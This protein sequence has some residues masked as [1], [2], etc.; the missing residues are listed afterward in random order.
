MLGERIGTGAVF[1]VTGISAAGKSTVA[2]LLARRFSRGV[3]VRGDVFRRMVV[4]GRQD[5][6][7]NGSDESRA[8][9]R[10]RHELGAA[11]A[12]RY[13]AAGFTAV[14]Q[15]LYFAE[16]DNVVDRLHSR[17]RYVVVLDPRPEVVAARE[18]ARQKTGYPDGGY[19]IDELHR[20]LLAQTSRLG[21]WLDNSDQTPNET[22]DAILARVE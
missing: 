14:L 11:V 15:D 5:M 10:V 3:H 7:A 18:A 22:V 21:L 1:V 2:D 8:Q 9:L 19:T 20:A 13:A 6:W 16:L 12:D 17:P 4:S